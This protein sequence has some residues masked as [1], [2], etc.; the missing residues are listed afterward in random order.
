MEEGMGLQ[1]SGIFY[2]PKSQKLRRVDERPD[3]RPAA[4]WQFVTH[5][6]DAGLH[7]CRRIMREWLKPEELGHVEFTCPPE[8]LSA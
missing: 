4:D 7:Q 1:M 5:N 6:V 2:D 3:G 8:Q